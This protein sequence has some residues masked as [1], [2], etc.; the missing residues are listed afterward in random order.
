[1]ISQ[2][3]REAGTENCGSLGG[4]SRVAKKGNSVFFVL[5]C[6]P[7]KKGEIGEMIKYLLK[8]LHVVLAV[9]LLSA[10]LLPTTCFAEVF[11]YVP[12]NADDTV[13]VIR[14]AD[15]SVIKTIPV[16][17]G[18]FKAMSTPDRKF[19][20]IT[21]NNENTVSIIRTSDNQVVNTLIVGDGPKGVMV[22]GDHFYI[23]NERENTVSIVHLPTQTVVN[24]IPVG[25]HPNM[26]F[27]L[28][29]GSPV[30][31][32]NDQEAT[33]SVIDPN[34]LTVIN[35][36][37]VGNSPK[38]VRYSFDRN[39]LY[40]PNFEDDTVSVIN[41]FD[42]N[43]VDTIAVGDGPLVI[44]AINQNTLYVTN[45]LD[46]SISVIDTTTNSV[47]NTILVGINPKGIR[48]NSFPAGRWQSPPTTVYVNNIGDNTISVIDTSTQAVIATIPTGLAPGNMR[49]SPDYSKLFIANTN[50][51]T[52]SV[53]RTADNVLID[54]ITT[55]NSPRVMSIIDTDPNLQVLTS[56]PRNDIAPVWSPDGS[57]LVF[58]SNR[59]GNWDIWIM[60]ADGSNQVQLTTDI[61]HDFQ[62]HWSPDGSQIIFKSFRD[63]HSNVWV[64]NAD[65]SNKTQ[66][67]NDLAGTHNI[68]PPDYGADYS[69]DG[70]QIVY[71]SLV[72]G[73]HDIWIMNV[74]GTNPV[75][76]TTDPANDAHPYF[77]PDGSKI[78]FWSDRSGQ[79]DIWVMNSDGTGQT[80]LTTDPAIEVHPH[81]NHD[82]TKIGF[83]RNPGDNLDIW[84]MNIKG[85]SQIP[86]TRNAA[87]DAGISWHPSG[88]KA[89]YIS[90]R[91]GNWDIWVEAFIDSNPQGIFTQLTS[92]SSFDG[93]P[94]ISP[95]GSKLLFLSNRSGNYDIWVKDLNTST[96]SQ[97]TT[98][99]ETDY[100]PHWSPDGSQIVFKS[101]RDGHANV[102]KM[103]ADGTNQ[104]QLTF[105][106][107]GL[108]VPKPFLHGPNWSPD[109]STIV[110]GRRT[111]GV[112]NI[113]SMNADGTNRIQLTNS[114][115]HETQP[116]FSPD[117]SKIVYTAAMTPGSFLNEVMIMNADGT[118]QVQL[119]NDVIN[120]HFTH[121]AHFSPDGQSIVY[122]STRTG[123]PDV[124]TMDIEGNNNTQITFN[125]AL[126]GG[127]NYG[128]DGKSIVFR[129]ERTGNSEIWLYEF[130]TD[131]DTISDS[132][133]NCPL[134]PNQDQ[135]DSDGDD[136]GDACFF[137][138][139]ATMTLNEDPTSTTELVDV[140]VIENRIV[141]ATASGLISGP[142]SKNVTIYR[143]LT[144]TY[145]GWGFVNATYDLAGYT[146]KLYGVPHASR[147]TAVGEINAIRNGE[148]ARWYVTSIN[149]NHASGTID[150]SGGTVISPG[151]TTLY[152]G[153]TLVKLGGVSVTG[154]AEGYY[155][156]NV[157]ITPPPLTG[158][159]IPSLG[160]GVAVNSYQASVGDGTQYV[161]IDRSQMPE[162]ETRHIMADGAL[163]RLVKASYT[164][165]NTA[166]SSFTARWEHLV[167]ASAN[168]FFE[169]HG[170]NNCP[171]DPNK[172]EPGTCGCGTPDTGDIDSDGILDCVD[173]CPTG[174]SSSCGTYI[175]PGDPTPVVPLSDFELTLPPTSSGGVVTGET[176]SNPSPPTNFR[177][178]GG[179]LYFNVDF[180]GDLG[181]GVA[182]VCL[183]YPDSKNEK[184][185]KVK[186][187]V[188]SN[189]DQIVDYWEDLVTISNDTVNNIICAETTSFSPFVVGF[190]D[191]DSDGMSDDWETLY[192]LDPSDPSDATED[193]LDSDGLTNLDEF[194]N[195]TEPDNPDTDGDG[196][197]DGEEV[198]NYGTDPTS[199]D[200]DGD[201]TSDSDE[202][203]NG[204]DP[205]SPPVTKVPV[206]HGLWLIPSMLT[207][208]YLL[209]RRKII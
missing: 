1:M 134:V 149:G 80:Q 122:R 114:P 121:H 79:K 182:T 92:D 141:E 151:T 26:L 145:A 192:G 173:S 10:F 66:L 172:T 116:S 38:F 9:Y 62:P 200:S 156:G 111:A 42:H 126:D 55:G 152:T 95:D 195:G 198:N 167:G 158:F 85:G 118:N 31:V 205:N 191:A 109:G 17:D 60:N 57:Q 24:T 84:T 180:T 103:N 135:L 87:R 128:P 32:T 159:K 65:G 78:V 13:S 175:P 67:T 27:A 184:N 22:S 14:V 164:P 91:T 162:K 15:H 186:H 160:G 11:G 89:A 113:W 41:A 90:E 189:N 39:Y 204:T 48:G 12:N 21:N 8:S 44:K 53:V 201:G 169:D 163:P 131:N 154:V 35:T 199:T 139:D 20:Y 101:Y 46:N 166:G 100:K 132:T 36:I 115:N 176:T 16:G 207:G 47:I 188:D 4:D 45:R 63:G 59:T 147:G 157:E 50:D 56:N 102:W 58:F 76:L 112:Y 93:A 146:G 49:F 99:P 98:N 28:N 77:S 54:T 51:N 107:D 117:G 108:D 74:D 123:N 2:T 81:F 88:L 70:T 23:T 206:H 72:N 105:D 96:L 5:I 19:V 64:M 168:Q 177:I 194:L 138:T 71:D 196:L 193:T 97:L 130:D 179:H 187:G 43:I 203:A 25:L 120:G 73:N 37:N 125:Q 30:Y 170:L 142:F 104:I 155:T 110:F 75:P 68:S 174:D 171:N 6:L 183:S 208:L 33:L 161:Y 181:G 197:T 150:I 209:R 190:P 82:G 34:S 140:E 165:L 148:L 83:G 7:K 69:P 136:R 127:G 129:S 137:V 61:D 153:V 106:I 133:D 119:T 124:W 3:C 86:F 178:P 18:P 185:Y 52:V 202:I 29:H 94:D 40:C 144:G 143:V